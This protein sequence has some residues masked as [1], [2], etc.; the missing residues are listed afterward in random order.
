MLRPAVS[1]YSDEM[2]WL[3]RR[4]VLSHNAA[5]L[6]NVTH[7]DR[8]MPPLRTFHMPSCVC[9]S[10]RIL[11]GQVGGIHSD[12][13]DVYLAIF[14]VFILCS[15]QSSVCEVMLFILS[16]T[17]RAH[18]GSAHKGSGLKRAHGHLLP[19]YVPLMP[20]HVTLPAY[21]AHFHSFYAV[22]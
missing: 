13:T 15:V 5:W 7:A 1:T 22:L 8:K 17:R 21:V 16:A 20:K 4:F 3:S 14:S 2:P 12:V 9:S 19:F 6:G 11:C 10:R 18:K